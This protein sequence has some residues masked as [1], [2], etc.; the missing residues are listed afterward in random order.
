M[1][2]LVL[3]LA[4]V[5]AF[6]GSASA[7]DL[8]ARPY[9]KA[10]PPVATPVYSWTGFWISGGFGYGLMD[11]ENSV[12][13]P[14]APF[15]VFDVGHDNGGRGWLGKVAGGGD[16]QFGNWVLGAFADYEFSDIA[17]NQS[18]NCP[19]GC[20]GPTGFVGQLK[21]DWSW[22]VGGRL[23][24]VAVPGLLTYFNGG[25]TEGH[26]KQVNFFDAALG[27]AT[28]LGLPSQTRDGWFIGGGTEY[29]FNWLPGLFLKSEYRFA[30]YGNKTFT[31][32]CTVSTASCGVSGTVH[33]LATSRIFEQTITTELVYRFNWGGPAVSHY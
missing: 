29:A 13:S 7:A 26:F 8:G 12:V 6:T 14:V 33:S 19:T 1:K 32:L 11:V 24:Y 15:P 18:F 2:K 25:F 28:G 9:T 20:I 3:A 31:Q 16:L 10:P 22:A 21:N 4:A 30:D 17:G 5:A 27:T 23:G